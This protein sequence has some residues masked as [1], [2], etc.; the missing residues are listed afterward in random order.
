MP[1]VPPSYPGVL[2]YEADCEPF[3][4][5]VHTEILRELDN[6]KYRRARNEIVIDPLDTHN[7]YMRLRIAGLLT[8]YERRRFIDLEPWHIAGLLIDNS[9]Q[10]RRTLD[11]WATLNHF[12]DLDKQLKDKNYTEGVTETNRNKRDMNRIVA[13]LV[14]MVERYP[15]K[16]SRA[17]ALNRL[18]RDRERFNRD[19]VITAL[20]ATN[21]VELVNDKLQIRR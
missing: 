9:R 6:N 2:K 15:G 16:L 20:L 14:T 10:V 19:D 12:D 3:G 21:K 11:D 13:V 1:Q 8:L 18:G 4:L 5:K 17:T 7:D